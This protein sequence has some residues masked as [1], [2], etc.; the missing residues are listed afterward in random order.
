MRVFDQGLRPPV[1]YVLPLLVT[2]AR[3]RP[4]AL[5]H[6]ALGLPART[7]VPGAGRLA[8]RPAAAA[9]QP[10]RDHVPRLSQR[11]A[12]RSLRRASRA[13]AGPDL[14]APIQGA[15][16]APPAAQRR[17]ATPELVRTALA[18]E[19]RGGHLCVFLPPLADGGDYAA[20]I[21]AIEATA[22][23]TRLPVRLEGYAPPYDRAPQRHQGHA[24]PRR[25]RGQRAP[26]DLVARRRWRSPRPSTTRRAPSASAPRSSCWTAATSAPAA[27]TTSCSAASR[28]PTAPSCGAPICWGASSPTGRTIPRS[29]TCSAACSSGRPARRRGSTR[30]ATISS[31]SW[32]S[33]SADPRAGRRD[34]ALAGRPPVP[35]PAGR[36]HRQHASRRDLHRQAL[37]AG[38]AH[39]PPR[40][41]R[42]PRLRDAAARAHE[43]RPAAARSARWWPRSGSAPTA[44]RWCAG[45]RRCTTASCCR[46]SSGRTSRASSPSCRARAWRSMRAGSCPHFEFRFPLWGTVAQEGVSL[47]LRQALE[48]WLVLGEQSGAGDRPHRGLLARSR[49]GASSGARARTGI[50]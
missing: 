5:P 32:R 25:H 2:A 22:A 4:P 17:E 43:P 14:L 20:L 48:P 38:G 45:A 11:A 8:D 9:G 12:G 39:G 24:R 44:V 18:I 1:G 26:G 27:A 6:R 15:A 7:P 50:R 19:P 36:P 42:V 37:R 29:P 46:T 23:K 33:R 30:R 21:A 31:T 13:S 41:R 3:W 28:R 34:R 35:Q 10:A 40:A 16:T 47:E 49:A